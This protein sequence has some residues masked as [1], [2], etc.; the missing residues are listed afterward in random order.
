MKGYAIVF[1]P[2]ARQLIKNLSPKTGEDDG[3]NIFI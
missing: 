2:S 3:G 1:W